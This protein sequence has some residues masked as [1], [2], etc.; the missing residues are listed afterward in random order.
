MVGVPS[1]PEH[2][3]LGLRSTLNELSWMTGSGI[4][5]DY[6]Y[7]YLNVGWKDWLGPPGSGNFAINYTNDSIDNGYIP[8]YDWYILAGSSPNIFTNLA[9]TSYM[10]AYYADFALLMQKIA[11]TNKNPVVVHVE[12]DLWGFMQ[13]VYGD[14]PADIPVAVASSG[15]TGLS[16]LPNTA[17]GFARAMI[18]IKNANAP[19]VKLAWHVNIWA[20]NNGYTP[21]LANP[22]S[23]QTP[24]ATGDR[25]A[26]FYNAL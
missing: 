6:R 15:Y 3:A 16:G 17:A 18:A 24:V 12:P 13:Q 22:A 26:V 10:A 9:S 19:Y 21:T 25:I 2:F 4:P 11:S 20:A 23:Y 7:Q 5:W 8:V 14:N 1:L